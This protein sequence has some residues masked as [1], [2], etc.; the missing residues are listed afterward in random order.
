MFGMMGKL[1]ELQEKVAEAQEGLKNI[2][3]T[4]ES[5]AGLVRA[6]A[7]GQRKLIKLEIDE[8][9]MVKE[10]R[11]VLA[12]LVVAAVNKAMDEAGEKGAAEMKNKTAGLMPNIPGMDFGNMKF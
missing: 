11:E 9:L 6:T 2:T 12:D 8:S 7:N 5:G 3:A 1:K 4:G 10:D